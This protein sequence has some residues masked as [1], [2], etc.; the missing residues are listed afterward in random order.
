M[1]FD[2]VEVCERAINSAEYYEWTVRHS[3]D[4]GAIVSFS[5]LVREIDS[6]LKS[7]R[8][9]T[10]FLEHY[11]GLTEN[12]MQM[13]ITDARA[14]WPLGAV[15]LVHRVGAMKAKDII[16]YLAVSA[17]HR[18]AAFE[19]TQ[20]IMD[21][22][23]SRVLLWKRVEDESESVWVEVKSSDLVAACRWQD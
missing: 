16:V 5:G 6:H 23:K 2:C 14:K 7:N 11:P 19:A 3:C 1:Q 12:S 9:D 8:L 18:L 10:L 4:D 20:F 13:V 15:C 17:Q 22:L 21:Q